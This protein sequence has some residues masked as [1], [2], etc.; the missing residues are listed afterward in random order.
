MFIGQYDHTI[1]SKGRIIVPAKYREALGEEF[2]A[3]Q[4]LDGCL[5]LYPS[6][7]WN[8]FAEKLQNLP[9]G[10]NT[11]KLQRHF[12]SRAMEM[13]VDKQGRILIPAKLREH[14]ALEKDVV[15]VGNINHVEVWN[16]SRWDEMSESMDGEDVEKGLEELDI[17]I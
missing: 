5:F 2:I 9:S 10:A 17:S 14:A 12:M 6:A 3:T 8:T 7:E 11:R 1:D 15:F 4:G 13:N 16:S